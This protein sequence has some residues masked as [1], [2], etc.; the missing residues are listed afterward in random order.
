LVVIAIIA[1]LA[2][3][4][5]PVFAQAKAAAKTASSISNLKQQGLALQ[6]YIN[7]YDDTTFLPYELG[8]YPVQ[9]LYPY[10]KSIDITWDSSS[11]IPNFLHPMVAM[12]AASDSGNPEYWGDWTLLGTLSWNIQGLE[13]DKGPRVLSGQENPSARAVALAFSNP[14]NQFGN[15]PAGIG[16]DLGWFI[17]DG[18]NQACYESTGNQNTWEDT[19]S[20][21]ITRAANVWH[22][23]GYIT[24]FMDGHAKS[25]KGMAYVDPT[26]GDCGSETYYW[27]AT[28]TNSGANDPN[29]SSLQPVNNWG[30]WMI[31]PSHLQ[32]WGTWWDP[33]N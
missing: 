1:I 14:V 21:G 20:A 9:N 25:V 4:L 2:A 8:T 12:G 19:P 13:T 16:G 27:W 5:F 10:V 28:N 15:A 7:D 17:F 30:A 26:A 29:L 6:M 18:W 3:I 33:S 32:Y 31:Q 24:A 11:P 23:Q 22:S